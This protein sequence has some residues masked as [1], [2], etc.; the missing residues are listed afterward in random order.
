MFV[1]PENW[2]TLTP[3]ERRQA[4]YASWLSTEGRNF[5]NPEAE[6]VY[7]R[8]TR[9]VVDVMNLEVPDAVP[10][11]PYHRRVRRKV[12]RHHFSRSHVRLREVQAG[13]Q[14]ILP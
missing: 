10:I 5:S 11:L 13:R 2:S 1:R 7:R 4:R 14:E 9:R 12:C 6:K 8:N 3:E